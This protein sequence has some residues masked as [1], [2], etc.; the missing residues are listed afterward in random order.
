MNDSADNRRFAVAYDSNTAV[1]NFHAEAGVSI[2]ENFTLGAGF[3]YNNY[4][5]STL[6]KAYHRPN[7]DAILTGKYNFANKVTIGADLFFAGT[8]YGG[9]WD[10]D[11]ATNKYVVKEY[12]LGN[13]IDL[14]T[15]ISYAF[16]NI[17]GLKAHL[18]LKNILGTKYQLWNFYPSRGFQISGGAS[19]SF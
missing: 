13:I 19:F 6:A 7:I 10:K 15:N 9:V 16:G 3:N 8:R 17:K 12:N 4:D 1:F 14:N 5:M 2:M 18:E 11:T